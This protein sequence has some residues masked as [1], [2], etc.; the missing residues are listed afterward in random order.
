MLNGTPASDIRPK[1]HSSAVQMVTSGRTTARSDAK[2][3]RYTSSVM[4]AARPDSSGTSPV[5]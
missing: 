4:I 1:V 3:T 5:M 2:L